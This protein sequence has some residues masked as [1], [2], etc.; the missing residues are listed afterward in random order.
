[1]PFDQSF[2]LGT[3]DATPGPDDGVSDNRQLYGNFGSVQPI[4]ERHG[5]Q[6]LVDLPPE[7]VQ[8]LPQ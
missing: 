8:C 2:S 4:E 1:M 6:K 5:T 3:F 7:L